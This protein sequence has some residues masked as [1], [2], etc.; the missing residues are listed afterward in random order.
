MSNL[1]DHSPVVAQITDKRRLLEVAFVAITAIGKFVMMDLLELR[2]PFIVTVILGWTVYVIIR[3]KAI[4][5]IFR[6]WGLTDSHFG[7]TVRKVIPFALVSLLACVAVGYYRDTIQLTWHII[8]ILIL[9]PLWGT[10]QQFLTIGLVA[11][12]LQDLKGKKLPS[13]A[14]ILTTASLFGIIHLPYWWLVLGTFLLAFFYAYVYLKIR[15]LWV[16]GLLHGWLG[17]I[18]FY[19][20]VGRDPFQ[21]VFG[22]LLSLQ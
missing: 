3:R 14:I 2:F 12:N 17:A 9:Y 15:N 11:G 7:Q 4:R 6:Y 20:V 18:F 10:V 1:S 19:T 16:L 5:G 22:P 8:P 21:E 13:W